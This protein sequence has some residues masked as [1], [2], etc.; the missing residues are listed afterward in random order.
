[1]RAV[2]L[3]IGSWAAG[4]VVPLVFAVAVGIVAA[5][6]VAMGRAWP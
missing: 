3:L 5:N 4:M 1:M 2:A 6:C